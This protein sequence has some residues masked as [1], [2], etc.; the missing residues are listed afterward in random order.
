M[1]CAAEWRPQRQRG[2]AIE[3]TWPRNGGWEKGRR[4]HARC[5]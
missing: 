5:A 4:R 2:N 3:R 1:R